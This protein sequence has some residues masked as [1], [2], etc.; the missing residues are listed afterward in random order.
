MMHGY[1][2]SEEPTHKRFIVLIVE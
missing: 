1:R 2:Q